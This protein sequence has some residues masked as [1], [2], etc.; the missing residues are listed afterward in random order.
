M[1]SSHAE[2]ARSDNRPARRRSVE[3]TRRLL[4]HGLTLFI[5]VIVVEF[6]VLPKFGNV[7]NVVYQLGHANVFLIASALALEA[8]AFLAY[9]KLTQ[10]VLP[11]DSPSY[12]R[13]LRIDMS[14]SAASH[15]LPGGTAPGT[16][17]GYRLLGEA[18]VS[19]PDAAFALATQGVGSAV[20][21]NALFWTSLIVSI[22][23]YGLRSPSHHSYYFLAIASAAVLLGALAG[24]MALLT[25]GKQ[26]SAELLARLARRVPFLDP[27]SVANG[28]LRLAERL[29]VLRSDRNLLMRA[30]A[31][32]AANW[33]FD[34]TALWAM[35]AAFGR[36]VSP[37]ALLVAYG[38]ANILAAIPV[39]PSGLGVIEW[40]LPLGL[41]AFGTPGAIA[42][43]GV[44]GW[45]L[46]NFWLPIP[47]GAATY[48]S[49]RVEPGASRRRKR[50]VL[51]R[52]ADVRPDRQHDN[53]QGGAHDHQA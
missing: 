47:V 27:Q 37:I 33:L 7:H 29:E 8:G 10:A 42:L 31:W 38:L 19:G 40:V 25:K 44:L 53:P 50:E 4:G 16:I 39:T 24:L 49:L 17:L 13:L 52:M 14:T 1:T 43:L 34:A 2:R 3:L 32:A 18:G 45:R 26:G 21:L 41:V 20:V 15:V 5:L 11:H 6:V 12:S 46:L 51:R 30:T 35:L 28:I 22:P 48:V 9:A 23:L 36:F